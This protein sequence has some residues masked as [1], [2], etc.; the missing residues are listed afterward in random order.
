MDGLKPSGTSY[1]DPP[2]GIDIVAVFAVH[3]WSRGNN[4]VGM[5][6]EKSSP[7]TKR[8]VG[9]DKISAICHQEHVPTTVF[10]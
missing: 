6:V 2:L 8:T 4:F 9:N 3:P 1:P 5:L 7:P 10:A